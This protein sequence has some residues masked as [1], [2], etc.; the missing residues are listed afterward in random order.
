MLSKIDEIT[1]A[2]QTSAYTI[3]EYRS[4]I[5]LLLDLARED[6]MKTESSLYQCRL[7]TNYIF[8]DADIVPKNG[9]YLLF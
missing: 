9:L 2:L 4:D 5:D 1:R 3:S 7:G 6:C 8:L